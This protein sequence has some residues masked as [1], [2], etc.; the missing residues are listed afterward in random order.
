MEEISLLST[1]TDPLKSKYKRVSFKQL[2]QA[3]V[4][5]VVTSMFDW[6]ESGAF[7]PFAQEAHTT[8]KSLLKRTPLGECEYI[9]A[10]PY[11]DVNEE[12]LADNEVR[13]YREEIEELVNKVNP[14]L[15][16]PMGNYACLSIL[17]KG[18]VY[19]KRGKEFFIETNGKTVSVIPVFHPTLVYL[20]PSLRKI[21]VEDI[22]NAYNKVILGLNKPMK[23]SYRTCMTMEEVREEFR[24]SM[25]AKVVSVDIE[26]TGLDFH[27]DKMTCFGA[28]YK[29]NTAFVVPFKH[30]ESPF[31]DNDI[32]EIR[33]L[34]KA[35]MANPGIKK[36]LANPK[37]DQKFLLNEGVKVYNNIHDI[38]LMH[39]LVDENR[40]HALSEIVKQY[41]PKELEDY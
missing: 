2:N 9:S 27:K 10:V 11:A 4:L 23:S 34:I 30:F 29:P 38:Q 24:N 21:F 8:I 20:E 33:E 6:F 16:I 3:D 5:F 25:Q 41:F 26:T 7:Y 13:P 40:G 35:L 32:D 19:N 39:S 15:I 22:T 18:G 31:S 37:F 1:E 17:K 12:T 36:I 14:K 28:S